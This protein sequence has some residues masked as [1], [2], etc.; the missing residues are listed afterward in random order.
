[1]TK[2]LLHEQNV[3]HIFVSQQNFMHKW[4]PN[5]NSTKYFSRL[6]PT[7]QGN[8]QSRL[9]TDFRDTCPAR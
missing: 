8:F 2:I 4:V 1:M 7:V 6:T 5:V 3:S 9:N